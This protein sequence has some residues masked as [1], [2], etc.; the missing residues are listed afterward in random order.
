MSFRNTGLF[1]LPVLVA[2]ALPSVLPA[3]GDAPSP[4]RRVED[5][6]AK[7][8]TIPEQ[9]YALAEIAWVTEP[10]D[11]AMAAY[12]RQRLVD[13]GRH[14]LLALD[15][16]V[17]SADPIYSADIALALHAA[18]LKITG[19]RPAELLPAMDS[20]LWFGSVDAKRLIIP[21]IAESRFRPAMLPMMDAAYEFPELVPLVARQLPRFRDD[22]ARFFLGDILHNGNREDQ[23]AAATALARIGGRCIDTLRDGMLAEQAEVRQLS[24]ESLLPHTGID[25]L[26]ALYE[27]LLEHPDDD[28]Q[29]REKV[30][31]RAEQ[32]E[33]LLERQLEADA[34][35]TG[36]T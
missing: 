25:S 32:L 1:A 18:R 17:A 30:R 16:A 29:L 14:A 31:R 24:V 10:R 8:K 5:I 15:R 33:F 4:Q 6:V 9:A 35:G 2:L 13:Y 36:D 28:E 7:H 26:T 20:I 11:P 21:A 22:R 23:R 27:Y 19:G 3:S 34:A 12:A